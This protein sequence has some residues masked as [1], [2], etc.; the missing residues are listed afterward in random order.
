MRL[1]GLRGAAH[2]NGNEGIIRRQV[3]RC[4]L[5]PAETRVEG[6]WFQLLKLQND[7]LLSSFAFNINLRR[8]SE[9]PANSAR[10]IV[11]FADGNEVSAKQDNCSIISSE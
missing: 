4:K 5:A 6:A 10:V 1:T 8:Y 11:R 9:D 2:L 7:K 3:G